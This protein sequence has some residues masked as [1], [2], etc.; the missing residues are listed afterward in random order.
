MGLVD[1]Y[2]KGAQDAL[3]SLTGQTKP[4]HKVYKEVIGSEVWSIT[5]SDWDKVYG[6]RFSI[7]AKKSVWYFTLPI[8]PQNLV[9]KPLM[10][11]KVTPTMGGIVEETT[12][13]QMWSIQMS[14]TTGISATRAEKDWLGTETPAANVQRKDV[15]KKFR[16]NIS[17]TG[18]LAGI[19]ANLNRTIAKVGGVADVIVD[20]AGSAAESLGSGDFKS[21]AADIAAGFVGAAVTALLPPLP[22]S[23]SAV[24]ENS[25]GFTEAQELQ[26]FFY[27]YSK[28]KGLA[29]KEYILRFTCFKTNQDWQVAVKDFSL[30]I[31]SQNPNLYKY[32][33]VLQGWDIKAP[34]DKRKAFDRFSRSGDLHSV[35]TI[36]V[37]TM[38]SLASKI[39]L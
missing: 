22:Y 12:G 30:Q 18:L 11:S 31:S 6:Y 27:M 24:N 4:L 37:G 23:G 5:G 35:N 32:S 16:D 2:K 17:T 33:I 10:A 15:A 7:I 38:Q 29:P 9:I 3:D 21:V 13:I 28:L 34:G 20:A 39:H 19:A 1:D 36:S 8:P 25:N 14:G 26:K